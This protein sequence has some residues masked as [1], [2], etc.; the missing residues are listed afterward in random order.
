LLKI[1]AL[2]SFKK[3]L[4]KHTH[5]ANVLLTQVIA[6]QPCGKRKRV[7]DMAHRLIIEGFSTKAEA[8][9]F[10]DWY[11]GAGERD[12]AYWFEA[13]RDEGESDIAWIGTTGPIVQDGDDLIM[14]VNTLSTSIDNVANSE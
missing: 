8:R 12:S 14:T 5:V 1:A 11:S 9:A 3:Y 7:F 2:A 4:Q 10:A 6:K 13:L